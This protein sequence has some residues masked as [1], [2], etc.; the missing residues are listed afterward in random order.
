MLDENIRATKL[1]NLKM[2]LDDTQNFSRLPEED[3]AEYRMKY[4]ELFKDI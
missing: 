3:Q 4:L 1:T 2:L